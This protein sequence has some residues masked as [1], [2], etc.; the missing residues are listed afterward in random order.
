MQALGSLSRCC[1]PHHFPGAATSVS[2]LPLLPPVSDSCCLPQGGVGL[3]ETMARELRGTPRLCTVLCG[4]ADMVQCGGVRPTAG[5][6][7]ASVH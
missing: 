5:V 3:R 1:C 7:M 4:G 6:P 2:R